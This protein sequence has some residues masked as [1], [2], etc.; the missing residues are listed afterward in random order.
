MKTRLYQG[1]LLAFLI[2]VA[3]NCANRGNPTGGEKDILPPKIVKSTPEN[4]STNFNN[5]EIVIYFD[6]YIKLKNVSKQLIISP[7][8]K[9]EPEITPLSTASKFIKIKII[10]TLEANTTY[11]FN[12]GNSI[13][14]NNEE[15]PFPYYRYVMSTGTYIDS[16]KVHGE[17]KDALNRTTEKNVLVN[18]YEVDSTYTDSIVF[19]EKPKYMTN[20]GDS[21][22]VFKIENIKAG[23]YKLIALKDE[24]QDY[25]FQQKTDKIAFYDDVITVGQDSVYYELQLFKEAINYR[26]LTPRLVSGEK[27]AFGFE[28]DYKK[29]TINNLSETPKDFESRIIKQREAD[30]LLYF[31][32]PKLE[33]DSLIFKVSA[34]KQVDTFTVKIKDNRKDTLL[35]SDIQKGKLG[36]KEDFKIH[37][38]IPFT[39]IDESKI[40]IM[41]KDSTNVVFTSELD[42][43]NNYYRLKFATT[44]ANR[45]KIEALPDA[46]TDFFENKSDTLR[47]NVSTPKLSNFTD[48]NRVILENAVYPLFVQFVDEK[49]EVKYEKYVTEPG[50][51]DFEYVLPGTYY[52]RVLLDTN[53]NGIYDA[54][55]F[56]KGEQPEKVIYANKPIEARAGWEEI[57]PFILNEN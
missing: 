47:F 30:S 33:V 34:L 50:N 11:S 43:L 18:L 42:S 28:G 17:V 24:N 32:K 23:T 55:N 21:T 8:M 9:Y 6:E 12:F 7:P 16:L 26:A 25:K 27:I 4:Y 53:K 38:N 14:D 40:K 48:G 36:L 19:K 51:V 35:I 15:N 41:D 20:T 13:V 46:F 29:M 10:D 45:Y 37:A 5:K 49:S 31:Y 22:S 1:L 39:A 44:E 3:F 57:T 2:I 52:L 56:L 54:G